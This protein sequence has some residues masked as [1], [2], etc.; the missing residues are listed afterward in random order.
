MI[1]NEMSEQDSDF[2]GQGSDKN[3]PGVGGLREVS[4]VGKENITPESPDIAP[5]KEFE[6]S[7]LKPYFRTGDAWFKRGNDDEE[8]VELL[9]EEEGKVIFKPYGS[10]DEISIDFQDQ[11]NP[12]K[13]RIAEAE[14]IESNDALKF[15]FSQ[16]SEEAKREQEKIKDAFAKLSRFKHESDNTDTEY[17]KWE[18]IRDLNSLTPLNSDE[19]AKFLEKSNFPPDQ[20]AIIKELG[21]NI[22]KN[23]SVPLS[24]SLTKE[25]WSDPEARKNVHDIVF[26]TNPEAI[27]HAAVELGIDPTSTEFKAFLSE[28]D[29]LFPNDLK[30]SK[31]VEEY[32]KTQP[33]DQ[34]EHEPKPSGDL[35]EEERL[36]RDTDFNEIQKE[37]EE[38]KSNAHTIAKK[39]G[40]DK[41]IRD[42]INGIFARLDEYK[43]HYK[44]DARFYAAIAFKTISVTLMLSYVIAVFV[45]HTGTRFGAGK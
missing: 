31:K 42:K 5:A 35:S 30:V 28:R 27:Y 12:N 7:G 11:D 33:H 24:N 9:R 45:L 44:S 14:L 23:L 6:A 3:T 19:M 43:A 37:A 36:E 4:G 29:L 16:T 18:F 8:R 2:G 25:Q 32:A 39:E 26:S 34:F 40:G 21:E 1:E 17:A 41:I 22:E 13:I 20:L 38:L 15:L 10:S